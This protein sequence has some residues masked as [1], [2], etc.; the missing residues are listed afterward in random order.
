LEMRD[1]FSLETLDTIADEIMM[2]LDG[3]QKGV[4]ANAGSTG[5]RSN[6]IGT[7]NRAC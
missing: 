6:G 1:E 3:E 2:V 4:D 5:P 7:N